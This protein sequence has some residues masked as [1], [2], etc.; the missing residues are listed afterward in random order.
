MNTLYKIARHCNWHRAP[1]GSLRHRLFGSSRSDWSGLVMNLVGRGSHGEYTIP[2][3]RDL[4]YHELLGGKGGRHGFAW[5]HD[6]GLVLKSPNLDWYHFA[7]ENDG[8][9]L[10]MGYYDGRFYYLTRPEQKLFLR[11]YLVEHKLRGEWFGLRRWVYYKALHRH[12]ANFTRRH[13]GR[14]R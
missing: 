9:E 13:A 5:T 4:Y 14:G 3:G 6:V 10:R 11:W 2:R 7:I 12:V 1:V 8:F